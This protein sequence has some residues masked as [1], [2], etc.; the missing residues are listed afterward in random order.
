MKKILL[1]S[2]FFAMICTCSFST[3]DAAGVGLYGSLGAGTADWDDDGYS[4]S[5]SNFSTDTDHK[6]AGF[7]VDTNLAGD[8]LFNYH[9]NLGYETF[10]I[11]DFRI[12]PTSF[13][14]GI[15][16][17]L[18]MKGIVMTHAFGFGA[19]VAPGTRF[20]MGPELRLQWAKGTPEKAQDV[21]VKMF[22]FGI[23][24]A[25]GLNFNLPKVTIG[26]KA[27]YDLV[28][29]NGDVEGHVSA[30]SLSESYEVDARIFYVNL[31]FLFRSRWDK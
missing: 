9:L 12:A 26:L 22:G 16:S 18:Q 30:A 8:D 31:E 14:P 5:Y 19:T 2:F 15:V 11:T 24:A 4:S 3:A 27:G 13:S 7:V 28:I 10:D 29:Y 17:D 21:D 20:W 23:G 1:F 6:A 25:A